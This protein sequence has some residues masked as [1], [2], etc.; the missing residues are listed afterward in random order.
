[1]LGKSVRVPAAV[2]LPQCLSL[3]SRVTR[4]CVSVQ[5]KEKHMQT[6]PLLRARQGIMGRTG[7]RWEPS[8]VKIC[9]KRNSAVK[10]AK[11][12][13]SYGHRHVKLEGHCSTVNKKFQ[14]CV[15]LEHNFTPI[16]L[17]LSLYVISLTSK[18][19]WLAGLAQQSLS[20]QHVVSLLRMQYNPVLTGIL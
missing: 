11:V 10:A 5:E 13:T 9:H 14:R 15:I 7:S 6:T 18:Q 2:S 19:W 12:P 16:L 4:H 17:S 3:L 20:N 1:M 8:K